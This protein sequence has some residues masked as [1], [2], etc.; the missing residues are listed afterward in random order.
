MMRH[1]CTLNGAQS[2]QTARVTD[3]E[4][5]LCLVPLWMCSCQTCFAPTDT[6]RNSFVCM[7]I[8]H[9]CVVILLILWNNLDIFWLCSGIQD[10]TGI[11]GCIFYS[12]EDLLLQSFKLIPNV[13]SWTIT[14][15][16][17]CQEFFMYGC[18]GSHNWS[19]YLKIV[20][21]ETLFVC[22]PA[23]IIADAPQPEVSVRFSCDLTP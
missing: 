4:V 23:G 1:Y 19:T 21:I 20:T 18:L 5:D 8:W 10:K 13:T 6:R 11:L 22:P 9:V 14:F 15:I 7:L 2:E 3:C 12:F 17:L 16:K